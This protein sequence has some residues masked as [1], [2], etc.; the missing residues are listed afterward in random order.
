MSI[1]QLLEP[2]NFNL[3]SISFN[4][5]LD[6]PLGNR[7]LN[8]YSNTQIASGITFSGPWASPQSST[9]VPQMNIIRNGELVTLYFA[10]FTPVTITSSTII[11]CN[12]TL[13][14]Q[15]IPYHSISI[16]TCISVNGALVLV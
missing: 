10:P 7:Q 14:E 13:L 11:T 5:S 9:A 8:Y 1:S 12:M 4:R 15:Y 2:N 16:P 6:P 3:Y